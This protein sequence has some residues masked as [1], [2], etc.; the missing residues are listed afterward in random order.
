MWEGWV[1][2]EMG[3]VR[4]FFFFLSIT[5][6]PQLSTVLGRRTQIE[7]VWGTEVSVRAGAQ[8]GQGWVPSATTTP[9]P[10]S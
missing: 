4:D 5:C 7:S 1:G 9:R 2:R 10:L 3:D 8:W 6:A